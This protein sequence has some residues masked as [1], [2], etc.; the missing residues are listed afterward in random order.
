[1]ATPWMTYRGVGLFRPAGMS[2]YAYETGR[3]ELDADGAPNA[4]HPDDIGLDAL[5]NA[6]YPGGGW[7][8]VLVQ[9]P[10]NPARPFVQRTGPTAGYF[11]SKTSLFDP[12]G[13]VTDPATYVDSVAIPYI[14]F[15]GD[16]Y[17]LTGTGV[18]GDFVVARNLRSGEVSAAIVADGGPADAELGEVSLG[19]ATALGGTNPNPR[20]GAGKPRGPFRYVVFPRSFVSPKWPLSRQQIE[21]RALGCL[22]TAGGWTTFDALFR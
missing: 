22:A 10:A 18:M 4:Y 6:G 5:A 2:A 9:D 19:L 16:F 20:N 7:R 14:V 15:P 17:N 13:A 8:N 12:A 1:M 3:M 11:L 21:Q